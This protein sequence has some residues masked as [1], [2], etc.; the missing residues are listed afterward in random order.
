MLY[1]CELD[2]SARNIMLRCRTAGSA[3][4]ISTVGSKKFEK[5][6]FKLSFLMYI[7]FHLYFYCHQ[8]FE[9]SF[10]QI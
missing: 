10:F 9:Y 3:Y 8:I 7:F 6:A 1:C 4:F 5:D 2:T